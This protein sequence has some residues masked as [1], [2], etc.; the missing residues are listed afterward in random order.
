MYLRFETFIYFQPYF[1]IEQSRVG[2]GF[3]GEEDADRQE[4]GRAEPHALPDGPKSLTGHFIASVVDDVVDDEHDDAD[5]DRSSESTFSDD[6]TEW[7]ADKE[8]D[9]TGEAEGV[10][11]V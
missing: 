10:F 6:G 9:E 3:V 11:A 1:G 2:S 5:D 7:C 4:Y 8:E